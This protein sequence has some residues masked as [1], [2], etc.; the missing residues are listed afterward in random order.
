MRRCCAEQCGRNEEGTGIRFDG[1]GRG[2]LEGTVGMGARLG[3]SEVLFLPGF[4]EFIEFIGFGFEGLLSGAV[5]VV[6]GMMAGA[7]RCIR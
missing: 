6:M 2:G 1:Y 5:V 3:Y 7:F 4:V